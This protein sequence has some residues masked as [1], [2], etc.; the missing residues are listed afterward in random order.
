MLES[1]KHHFV[2]DTYI[3]EGNIPAG[4]RVGKHQ[5]TYDHASILAKGIAVVLVDGIMIPYIAPHVIEIKANTPHEILAV[6]DVTWYCI[7]GTTEEINDLDAVKIE[8]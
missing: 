7:H 6:T 8:D 5:H 1:M 4:M 3:R 2:A